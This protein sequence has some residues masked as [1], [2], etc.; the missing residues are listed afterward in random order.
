[1][2]IAAVV[3]LQRNE[4]ENEVEKQ[5]VTPDRPEMWMFHQCRYKPN[6]SGSALCWDALCDF[7]L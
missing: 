5:N 7:E 1:M 6:S 4:E 3:T 2:E